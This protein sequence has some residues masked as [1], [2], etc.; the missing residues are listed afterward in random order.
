MLAE[1]KIKAFYVD[2]LCERTFC[3]PRGGIGGGDA[4]TQSAVFVHL[5]N[6]TL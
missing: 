6:H 2:Y 3:L 1:N 4:K 5:N